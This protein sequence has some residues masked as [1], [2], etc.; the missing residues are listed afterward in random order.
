MI[1]R[2]EELPI[3]EARANLSEI[4]SRVRH[5]REPVRLTRR[6][7]PQAAIVTAELG[8]AAEAAGGLDRA[9]EILRQAAG[10]G[11]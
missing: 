4:T 1:S 8:D 10:T 5:T 9:A 7:S 2:M 3:A 11:K 6:G